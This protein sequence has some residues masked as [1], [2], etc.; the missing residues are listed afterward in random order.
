MLDKPL[1]ACLRKHRAGLSA[2]TGFSCLGGLDNNFYVDVIC[3]RNLSQNTFRP[4]N[5]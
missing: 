2:M 1:D 5:V 4:M 3:I